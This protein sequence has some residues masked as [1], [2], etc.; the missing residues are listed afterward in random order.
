M[1]KHR[2]IG[3]SW[4]SLLLILVMTVQ[5]LPVS[6]IAAEVTEGTVTAVAQGNCGP[7][8][9][10]GVNAENA[11]W[12][13]TS[14][15]T[16]TISGIGQVDH[17]PAWN[18]DTTPIKSVVIGEGIS[19]VVSQVGWWN[20][21]TLSLPASLTGFDAEII[22]GCGSIKIITLAEGSA[23]YKMLDGALMS[24]DG[25]VLCWHP[26]NASS[27]TTYNVPSGVKTI[28]D[29]ALYGHSSLRTISLPDGLVTIGKQAFNSCGNLNCTLTIPATVKVMGDYCLSYNNELKIIIPAD[30]VLET[31]GKGAMSDNYTEELTLPATLKSVGAYSLPFG[32]KTGAVLTFHSRTVTFEDDA[33]SAG[34]RHVGLRLHGHHDGLHLRGRSRRAH[35][36]QRGRAAPAEPHD[37]L[38]GQKQRC[39]GR[40][41]ARQH[42]DPVG[43]DDDLS[44]P[45]G[46]H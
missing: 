45:R 40:H 36:H 2:R 41:G 28:G 20:A 3:R 23:T 35:P 26:R 29:Y 32:L 7:A 11:R 33:I 42:H 25:T 21:E 46:D 30:S 31:I 37:P 34:G 4:I 14:D 38:H 9:E 17:A 39:D 8:D 44:D 18:I 43:H 24:K 5:L 12:V 10:S 27:S 16:L 15:G 1:S 19:E 6:V 13:L 22:R